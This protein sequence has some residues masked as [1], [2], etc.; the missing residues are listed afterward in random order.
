MVN[1]KSLLE[2]A[3]HS[4]EGE[5]YASVA[6]GPGFR[7]G[8]GA[9]TVPARKPAV[10]IEVVLDPFPE[11]PSVSPQRLADHSEHLAQLSARGYSIVCDEDSTITCERMVSLVTADRE[12]DAVKR[13]LRSAR[14]GRRPARSAAI[15]T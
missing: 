9:R 14:A 7:I 4:D 15:R 13:L 5:A 1:A 6:R 12:V 2:R 3:R 11:R 10:F 8:L